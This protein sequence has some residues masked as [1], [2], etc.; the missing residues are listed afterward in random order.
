LQAIVDAC[1]DG[2]LDAEVSVVISNNSGSMVLKRAR[3]EGIPSVHLSGDTHP[4]YED[5]D[6]AMLSALREH[7]VD[8]V[9]LA[10]FMKKLG[11]QIMF[12]YRDRILNIHPAL[13]P[14]FGGRGLFGKAV[15][16]AVFSSG[17]K[18][19]GVTI[20]IV[21]DQYDH[22]PIIAQCQIAIREDDTVD[23]LS[24]RV[25]FQEHKFLVETLAK[26]SRG[27]IV[28]DRPELQHEPPIC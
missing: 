7:D 10:G 14:R 22:G 4:K 5:L 12:S 6:R 11:P 3:W 23:S 2:R 17:E 13:L 15:H 19:T 28:L 26:I 18:V 27:E 25:V 1:K 20:H 16:E 24:E 21:D 9:I 8:L